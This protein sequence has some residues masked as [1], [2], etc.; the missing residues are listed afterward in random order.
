MFFLLIVGNSGF[1]PALPQPLVV[2]QSLVVE[3]SMAAEPSQPIAAT[4]HGQPIE[5][6]L[7]DEK[8]FPN[9]DATVQTPLGQV[10]T[11]SRSIEIISIPTGQ[12]IETVALELDVDSFTYRGRS[13]IALSPGVYQ[14][15]LSMAAPH[16]KW[17][18]FLAWESVSRPTGTPETKSWPLIVLPS[19]DSRAASAQANDTGTGDSNKPPRVLVRWNDD[20]NQSGNWISNS[21]APGDARD[22][23]RLAEGALAPLAWIRGS[24][25]AEN[26]SAAHGWAGRLA[27]IDERINRIAELSTDGVI[28]SPI[29]SPATSAFEQTS[30]IEEQYLI[31]KCDVLGLPVWRFVAQVSDGGETPETMEGG[32]ASNGLTPVKLVDPESRT[33]SVADYRRSPATTLRGRFRTD[34]SQ[35]NDSDF[36][37]FGIQDVAPARTPPS[38]TTPAQASLPPSPL[39]N[40]EEGFAT[41]TWLR[42]WSHW[43]VRVPAAIQERSIAGLVIDESLISSEVLPEH[44]S[45]EEAIFIWRHLWTADSHW[46]ESTSGDRL[47]H[48]RQCRLGSQSTFVCLNQT[49]WTMTLTLPLANLVQWNDQWNSITANGS[50]VPKTG[51]SQLERMRLT[52]PAVSMLGSTTTIPPMGMIVCQ[53]EHELSRLLTFGSRIQGG[54][55]KIAEV[56]RDVTMIV[57]HMGLL[58]ELA[59]LRRTPGEQLAGQ[60]PSSNRRGD[61]IE[62]NAEAQR[63]LAETSKSAGWGSS[64]WSADRWGLGRA[65]S[66]GSSVEA[67]LATTKLNSAGGSEQDSLASSMATEQLGT[68]AGRLVSDGGEAARPSLL[69]FRN[70]L[71]NGGFEAASSMGIAG[72]MHSQHPVDA[73]ALDRQ[74]RYSGTSAVR[75]EGKDSR[76]STT[77]LISRDLYPPE[78][79][80]LGVSMALRG[81]PS[82][83]D[84]AESPQP[85]DPQARKKT[86]FTTDP[87]EPSVIRV[88]I[89]GERNGHPIRQVATLEIP[90]DGQWQPGTIALQWLD[91]DASQDTN[92]RLTIDNYSTSRIWVDDVVVTDYFASQAERTELQ[93]LAYL[94]V[95]GLQH[96]DLAPAARLLNNY[97]AGELLRVANHQAP[98]HQAP[99]H[100]SLSSLRASSG[101][102]IA[103]VPGKPSEMSNASKLGRFMYEPP[104]LPRSAWA[105]QRETDIPTSSTNP[106]GS[107]T[108]PN[109]PERSE[110][111]SGAVERADGSANAASKEPPSISRRIR[112]WL[113]SPL[114]F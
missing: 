111:D 67:N 56:T 48:V 22:R 31:A 88:A 42:D 38:P 3:H 103:E 94:A 26:V 29:E 102:Q 69:T 62:A 5:W 18:G 15:E 53:T 52:R 40:I 2:A 108:M 27:S 97:W 1:H 90:N 32:V 16:R 23:S 78:T 9:S 75:L 76:G 81:E 20:S 37:W 82:Q 85:E 83:S 28:L 25:S 50:S 4:P 65:V 36:V 13:Q 109:S 105:P 6:V 35:S 66:S 112:G 58:G 24:G 14:L 98:N 70:L 73:V 110:V 91:L 106:S 86:G 101:S 57:E 30:K 49:P 93:S 7:R 80:R 114:R 99:N 59:S 95:N 92:L 8:F 68:D 34:M 89:E 113:P 71:T 79:G 96:S 87:N 11:E 55:E 45:V 100:Q 39:E 61:R 84:S 104:S 72:W 64:I 74:T 77:W 47:V 46:L 107:N 54:A 17:L 44:G 41:K 21:T 12:V 10:P 33:H 43:V 19:A 51:S 60:Y 63:R